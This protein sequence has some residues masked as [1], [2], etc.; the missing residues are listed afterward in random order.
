MIS[1][2]SLR[3]KRCKIINTKNGEIRYKATRTVRQVAM[4]PILRKTLRNAVR[5]GE[6][7]EKDNSQEADPGKNDPFERRKKW[8]K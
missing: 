1:K 3:F 6:D 8:Y 4:L 5:I 7:S 2:H